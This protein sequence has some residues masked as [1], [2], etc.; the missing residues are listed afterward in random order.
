MHNVLLISFTR[1]CLNLMHDAVVL[2]LGC[3]SHEKNSDVE[4]QELPVETKS[5]SLFFLRTLNAKNKTHLM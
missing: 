5:M 1:C 2:I 3:L 4:S